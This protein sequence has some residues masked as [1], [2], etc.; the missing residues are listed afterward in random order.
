MLRD[1]WSPVSWTLPESFARVRRCAISIHRCGPIAPLLVPPG[2]RLF[3]RAR[4]HL[5]LSLLGL[6]R[7]FQDL[8][9]GLPDFLH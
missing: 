2:P 7:L 6:L 1:S 3:L 8:L 5:R 9:P 4:S